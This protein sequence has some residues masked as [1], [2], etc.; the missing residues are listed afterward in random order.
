MKAPSRKAGVVCLIL[1]V[2][3]VVGKFVYLGGVPHIGG[4]LALINQAADWLLIAGY[5][6]LLLSVYVL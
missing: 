6:L 1:F 4:V 2:L 5:G 3:G